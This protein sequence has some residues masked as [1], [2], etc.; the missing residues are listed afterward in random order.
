MPK[1]RKSDLLLEQLALLRDQPTS[2]ELIA[3]LRQIL[4][5]KQAIAITQAAKLVGNRGLK[6][7]IPDLVAAFEHLLTKPAETDPN[8]HAKSAI[9]DA[10]YHLE[11]SESDTFLKG[12]R[13]IQREP[14]WGGQTDTAAKLRGICAMGLVRM[15]YLDVMTELA[16]LLADPE[17][18]ARIAAARAI[19][20]SGNPAGI[21]LLRLRSRAGDKP[22]VIAECLTALLQLT[23]PSAANATLGFAARFLDVPPAETQELTALAI[24]E[25]RLDGAFDLLK[26]WWNQQVEPELRKTGLL[27][28]A[29][30]RSN[31]S[32]EFL[33]SLIAKG[34]EL[35]AKNAIVALELYRQDKTFW[36]RV[37]AAVEQ[38][39]A[40]NL[41][42]H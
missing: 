26:S 9:A 23:P 37:E 33:L 5:S 16:D 15:N 3:Q 6:S 25:S 19:A 36:E 42:G 29:M 18:P 35:D 8:C 38:R 28:I 12:I 31:E 13:H 11:A 41:L 17:S 24:G 2:E 34:R 27:A 14:V 1:A 40:P 22:E 30:I 39:G 32:I 10:L 7:L 21:P 4:S 20:Y